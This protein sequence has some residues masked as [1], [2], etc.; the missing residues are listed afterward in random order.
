[1]KPQPTDRS[2]C[3]GRSTQDHLHSRSRELLRYDSPVRDATFWICVKPIELAHGLTSPGA[4]VS[5]LI[6][7]A[8]RD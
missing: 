7:S 4:P 8:S 1:M 5:L 6:G 3:P 2:H